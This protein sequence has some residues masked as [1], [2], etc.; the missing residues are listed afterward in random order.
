MS[1]KSTHGRIDDELGDRAAGVERSEPVGRAER[2]ARG[3]RGG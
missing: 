1:T 2:N 3:A